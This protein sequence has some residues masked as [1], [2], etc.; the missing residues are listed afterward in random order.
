MKYDLI[1]VGGGPGGLLAAKK[2]AEDGLKVILIERK[3]DITEI[4]RA[5][6]QIF[7]ID[8]ISPT[9]GKEEGE[10]RA[11]GY[12]DPVS[13]EILPEKCRFTF[14][15]P[16]FSIEY[17]GILLPYY[18]W[19]NISPSGYIIHTYK[20]NE[21]IW[22]FYFQKEVLLASLLSSA[23]KAGAEIL[24][25]T[26]AMG[27][28]NTP[29]G[30][31]VLMRG[32]SGE[33][34]IEA[35]TA[36]AA[37]GVS[38]IIVDSLGLNKDRQTM[39]PPFKILAYE[40]EGVETGLPKYSFLSIGG[41]GIGLRPGEGGAWLLAMSAGSVS[42][43]TVLDNFMKLPNFAPWFRNARIVKKK[44]VGAD[45]GLRTPIREPVSGNVTIVGDAGTPVETWV[46]GALA[47]AY[48]AVEA[49][50]KELNGQKGYPEYIGWWRKAL[51]FIVPSTSGG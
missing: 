35:R 50:E 48:M 40:M 42:P 45:V 20:P 39:T 30:V 18:N 16:G 12:I 34:T 11:D 3:R 22:G 49:I 29:E 17:A 15:V 23:Q 1:V 33:Q 36:I 41:I 27:V 4:N 44:A 13:V 37:D 19:I 25:E 5:C 46:Q 47:S 38:S 21:H 7:Y 31:K 2:A 8:K 51:P 26:L 6:L 10:R 28:E 9:G 24:T 43:S 14:P 32:K